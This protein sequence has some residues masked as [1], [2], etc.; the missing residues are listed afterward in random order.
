[1]EARGEA[2]GALVR[3]LPDWRL[4]PLGYYAVWPDCSRRE[5]LT[6]KFVRFLAEFQGHN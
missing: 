6:L 4:R 2:E 5:N 3:L 1:M